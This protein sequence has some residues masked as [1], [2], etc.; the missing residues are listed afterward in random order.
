MTCE[1]VTTTSVQREEL[2][3]RPHQRLIIAE[4]REEEN[5]LIPQ[6]GLLTD[7]LKPGDSEGRIGLV[8][9]TTIQSIEDIAARLRE[10]RDE[11]EQVQEEM[12]YYLGALTVGKVRS[13]YDGI[14]PLVQPRTVVPITG[15]QTA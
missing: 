7:G 1:R 12:R 11:L 5:R 10:R 3:K 14:H 13:N 8:D 9:W 6:V 15:I 2:K 4:L